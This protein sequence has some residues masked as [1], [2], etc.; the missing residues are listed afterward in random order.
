MVFKLY[1]IAGYKHKEIAAM[2]DIE[3]NTS[4]SQ[5]SRA[6]KYLQNELCYM[7]LKAKPANQN[8]DEN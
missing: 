5:L 8:N 6:K 2:L 3:V 1:V 4:K 7:E